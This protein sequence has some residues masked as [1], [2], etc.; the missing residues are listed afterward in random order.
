MQGESLLNQALLPGNVGQFKK[1]VDDAVDVLAKAYDLS[2]AQYHTAQRAERDKAAPPPTQPVLKAT[3]TAPSASGGNPKP[4]SK[5]STPRQS[6][7]KVYQ[8]PL[9]QVSSIA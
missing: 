5:L 1:M 2:N 3:P 8:W 7:A 6:L 4:I 9:T